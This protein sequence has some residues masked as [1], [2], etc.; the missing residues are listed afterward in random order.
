M[1]NVLGAAVYAGA[2]SRRRKPRCSPASDLRWSARRSAS[3][4]RCASPSTVG[5]GDRVGQHLDRMRRFR[6]AVSVA[7]LRPT[8]RPRCDDHLAV[9]VLHLVVE[10]FADSLRHRV[11]LGLVAERPRHPATGRVQWV[12]VVARPAQDA[13]CVVVFL[14]GFLVAVAVVG[15]RLGRRVPVGRFVQ[16]E[17]IEVLQTP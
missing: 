15:Q 7:E 13:D 12:H 3:F 17:G 14:R 8:R 5:I 1:L 9:G 11:V 16:S 4:K 2:L 10:N 6:F